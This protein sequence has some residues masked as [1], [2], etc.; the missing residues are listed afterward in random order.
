MSRLGLGLLALL[1]FVAG[2]ALGTQWSFSHTAEEG[3]LM[4]NVVIRKDPG[5]H[6]AAYDKALLEL[7]ASGRKVNGTALYNF[8]IFNYFGAIWREHGKG[9]QPPVILEIGPGANLGQGVLFVA[10]GARKYIGLDLYRDPELYNRRSYSA[11][12]ELLNLVAPDRTLL[13]ADQIYTVS[14]EQVVFNPERIQ[15]LFP[16]QSFDIGLPEG[17]IDFVY[18]ASVFEHITDVEKT[19]AA[20]LK[21]LRKG[22]ISAHN[23]DMRDHMDFSKPLEFLKVDEPAW[24]ARFTGEKAY[25]YTNRRRLSDMVKAM[26]AAGFKILK[27]APGERTPMSEEIRAGLHPDFQKYSLEDLA[28]VSALIVAEKP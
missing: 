28:V 25:S 13:R 5:M 20:I 2:I 10:T 3:V 18:S 26:E 22:G 16:R 17:S 6:P 12:Y 21:V 7:I 23:F 1:L 9:V 4:A 27:V 11:A 14:R 8:G 15:F 24:K 19:V